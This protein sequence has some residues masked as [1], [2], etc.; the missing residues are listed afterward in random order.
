M[1]PLAVQSDLARFIALVRRE[2]GARDANVFEAAEAPGPADESL[3]LRCALPDGQVL[4]VRYDT[5]PSDPEAMRRRLE[6]LA[7]TFDVVVEEASAGA[8][9]RPPAG[10]LLRDELR[11]LCERAASVNALVIDANSPILW[12]AAWPRGVAPETGA[13]FGPET[14]EAGPQPDDQVSVAATSRRALE[15]V[16]ALVDLAAL[17]KGKRGRHVEREGDAPFVAHSFAGIYLLTVV[18]AAP[19]DELRAERAALESLPRIERLVLALPPLDTPPDQG[20]GVVAIR[21][22]RRQ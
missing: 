13:G 9:S 22:P 4:V 7:S 19:F 16:R 6:M 5:P 17:R 21:R 3:E 14:D 2:L 18:F 10:R 12:G 8:R 11:T 15:A 20:A 1:R